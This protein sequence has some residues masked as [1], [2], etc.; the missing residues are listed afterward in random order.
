MLQAPAAERSRV[1]ARKSRRGWWGGGPPPWERWPG[2]SLKLDARWIAARQRWESPDGFYFYD[3]EA[4]D[5][6]VEFFPNF[7]TLTKA[8]SG[9]PFTL[10]PWHEW[11]VVRPLFGWKRVSDGLRRFGKVFVAAP[12]GNAK[13]PLGAGLCIK[14]TF[15]DGENGADGYVVAGDKEQAR[16]LFD[17]AR[18]MVESNPDMTANHQ[19]PMIEVLT[20]SIFSHRSNSSMKLVSSTAGT[21]HGTRP[22]VVVIDEMHVQR[23]RNLF[24]AFRKSMGKR[25]Q[26]V[27]IMLTHAGDDEE[28]ICYEEWSLCAR[29]LAGTADDDTY[30]PVIFAATP[31]EDPHDPKTW[32]RVNPGL[33]V[34]MTVRSLEDESKAA[35]NEPRKL[36]DF[37]R[38]NLNRWVNDASSWIPLD[39]W[40]SCAAKTP[41]DSALAKLMVCG[42]LDMAQKIDLASFVLAFRHPMDGKDLTLE[43]A[44]VDDTTG[45]P[46]PEKK[47]ALNLNYQVTLIPMFWIPE[48]TMLEREKIDRVPYSKWAADG[49]IRVTEGGIID[50]EVIFDDIV[51]L[52][53]RFPLLKQGEIGY[54]PAFATSIA[55][56]LQKKGLKTVEVKQNYGLSEPSHMLEALLKNNRV[57][58]GGHRVLRWC[59]ENVMV[60]RDDAGRIRPVK[61]RRQTKRIDGIVASIMALSR[62]HFMQPASKS[63][64]NTRGMI[65]F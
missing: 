25:E 52:L 6:A 54:D 57:N 3:L 27:L 14:L 8:R 7:L 4:A 44:E 12:K 41:Q 15:A 17:D 63:I 53:T 29:L 38:Y 23:D 65:S 60:K 32:N 48:S 47:R 49:L 22:H 30:L 61:P 11:L 51:A 36:H 58:H 26:P 34:S 1:K 16:V 9:E 37:L 21:K 19:G 35:R 45:K 5:K 50:E 33:G 40:D 2:T 56:A 31:D 28:S 46:V 20:N 59:A 42:G 18:Q 10:M 64:Y 55:L 39:V 13:T 62:L 24:E 43:V